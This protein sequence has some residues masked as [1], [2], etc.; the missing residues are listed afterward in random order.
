MR[1]TTLEAR[2]PGPSVETTRKGGLAPA[3]RFATAPPP[4]SAC[5]LRSRS[6]ARFHPSG[7]TTVAG[8]ELL[9]APRP[10]TTRARLIRWALRWHSCP[11]SRV[12]ATGRRRR[13]AS[14]AERSRSAPA[15]VAG[16]RCAATAACSRRAG[17]THSPF[18]C[19][20]SDAA[21]ARSARAGVW[22]SA[23]SSSRCSDYSSRCSSCIGCSV[24][25]RD[26]D[27]HA[28][29]GVARLDFVVTLAWS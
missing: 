18:A 20:A 25:A 5:S 27:R 19:R 15:L 4:P 29:R 13:A 14:R 9:R 17:R 6:S 28:G 26:A 11:I 21:E 3:A 1:V 24:T 12:T 2:A 23:G 16:T 8:A 10:S 22:C 7:A